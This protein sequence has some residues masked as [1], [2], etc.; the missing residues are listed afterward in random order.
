MSAQK[1][2][3]I[4]ID[5]VDRKLIEDARSGIYVEPENAAQFAD[6]VFRLKQDSQLCRDFGQSGLDFV[7]RNFDRKALAE[8]YMKILEEMVVPSRKQRA[9]Q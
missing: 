8:K 3:I 4:G 9:V 7:K 1:P 5:G 6:A 2:V